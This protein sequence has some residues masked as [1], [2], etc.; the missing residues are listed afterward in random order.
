MTNYTL[1]HMY[2]KKSKSPNTGVSKMHKHTRL[3]HTR[4]LL[5][6]LFTQTGIFTDLEE[7]SGKSGNRSAF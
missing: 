4:T 3:S 5:F 1:I 7:H 2:E 6:P